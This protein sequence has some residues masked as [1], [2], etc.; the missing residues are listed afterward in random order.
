MKKYF[1]YLA[2]YSLID[3]FDSINSI[4]FSNKLEIVKNLHIEYKTIITNKTLSIYYERYIKTNKFNIQAIRNI[5]RGIAKK[6]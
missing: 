3:I 2:K 4:T 1:N 5:L 6:I